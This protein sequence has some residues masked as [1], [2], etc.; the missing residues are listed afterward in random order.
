MPDANGKFKL[1]ISV[2][3]LPWLKQEPR[4]PQARS[5]P[6]KAKRPSNSKP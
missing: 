3:E 2:S 1:S 4:K 5:R 6:S